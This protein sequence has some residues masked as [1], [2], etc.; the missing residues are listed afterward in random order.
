[1]G[2]LAPLWQATGS[3]IWGAGALACLIA[4]VRLR[5]MPGQFG[6]ARTALLAAVAVTALWALIGTVAGPGSLV[7]EL[8]SSFRNLAWLFALL[9]LFEID[10]RYASLPPARCSGAG[11]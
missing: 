6:S 9:R 1:M 7:A 5:A 8:A 10:G 3:V 11:F 4:A 2:T